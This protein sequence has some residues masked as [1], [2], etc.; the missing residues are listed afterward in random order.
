VSPKGATKRTLIQAHSRTALAKL[1]DV[2]R[3][4]F[5]HLPWRDGDL[6][7]D[8]RSKVVAI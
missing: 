4:L 5:L 8:V 2:H 6:D 7:H 1:L 3:T